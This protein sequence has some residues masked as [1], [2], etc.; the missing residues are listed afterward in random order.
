[1]Q[2]IRAQ[3]VVRFENFELDLRA[4]ELRKNG[5]STGLQEQSIRILAML[6]EHRGQIVLREDIRKTLWPNDTVVEFDASINSAMKRLRQA[7]GDSAD[8]PR[9]IE[10]LARRGY[11]WTGTVEYSDTSS[12]DPSGPGAHSQSELARYSGA[13]IGKRVSHYLVLEILGGGGMGLVYKAEDL[14]LGRQVALKFLPEEVASDS[15]SLQRFEREARTASSLNHP[16]ICTIYEFGEHERQPF[17]VMEL[18][19]GQTLREVISDAAVPPQ[20]SSDQQMGLS[21][22]KL[23]DIAIQVADGLDAAHQKGILHRDIKPANIFIT[24]PGQAKI[25]DFGLA[26]LASYFKEASAEE[27]E[28]LRPTESQID[29][30]SIEHSLTRTG[31]A[32]GTAGYMSPEQVRGEKLDARSDLFSFGLVLYEMATGKRAFSGDTAAVLKDAIVNRTPTPPR[33]VNPSLPAKLERIIDRSIE[34]DRERRYQSASDVRTDLETLK[35]AASSARKRNIRLLATVAVIALLLVAGSALWFGKQARSSLPE[36]RVRQLTFN[37]SENPVKVSSSISPDGKYLAYSD[38]RGSHVKLLE[39]GETNNL[40]LPNEFQSNPNWQ[41]VQWFPN[42]ARLLGDMVA[43]PLPQQPSIWTLSILGGGVT[44]L[45]DHALGWSLSPDGSLIAFGDNAIDYDD[46]REIWLMGADGR[47]ARKVFE[48]GDDSALLAVRWSPDGQR[49]LYNRVNK[50]GT[51]LENRALAGGPPVQLLSTSDADLEDYSWLPDGRII[52][53]RMDKKSVEFNCELWEIRVDQRSGKAIGDPKRITNWPGVCFNDLS[54]TS[55]GKHLTFRKWT[56]QNSVYLADIEAGGTRISTPRQLT[57]TKNKNYLSAWTADSKAVIFTSRG[58]GDW[59]IY[60]Q[61]L[62]QNRAEP[63]LAALPGYGAYRY[64]PKDIALPRATPD[65]KWILYP[66]HEEGNSS[67]WTKLMRV[68]V[69]GG[70][71]ELVLTGNF[72]EGPSCAN[73]PVMLCV[74]AEQSQDGNQLTLSAVDP[75]KGRGRELARFDLE[76]SD[77]YD[78]ALSPDGTRVALL[79]TA[80][81]PIH[82]L[83]LKGIP[84]RVFQVK[85][86]NTL[87]S[88]AWGANGKGL[89]VSGHTLRGMDLMYVDLKGTSHVLWTQDGGGGTYAIPSPDGRHLAIKSSTMDSNIWMMENF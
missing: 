14:K 73:P 78:W 55:D 68:P 27:N 61:F 88:V 29:S 64:R 51:A 1:M 48:A 57:A 85:D 49:L 8:N 37:S 58:D 32:M 77:S 76:P 11:R 53:V 56:E 20:P 46:F 2:P 25:L 82:I 60:K 67:T 74:I 66:L 41:M 10:T 19:E 31:L 40:N 70:Q 54:V 15:L 84:T 9:F 80:K 45:R 83:S 13:L 26:K 4:R 30:E 33:S 69:S 24:T 50:S 79:D 75:L 16:N 43:H 65:G 22:A 28:P 47:E 21:L 38:Y 23:L 89:F 35:Q 6:L 44:K 86:W 87:D 5:I 81:G 18:L 12:A 59:G 36:L 7:L 62:D 34:K 39:T 72:Y 52:Y 17:I 42:G 63:V 3:N 71:P